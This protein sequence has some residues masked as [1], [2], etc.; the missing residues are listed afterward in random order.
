MPVLIT[1]CLASFILNEAQIM[2]CEH[3]IDYIVDVFI[4]CWQPEAEESITRE[5]EIP[6]MCLCASVKILGMQ[7]AFGFV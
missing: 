6:V 5:R 3:K 4:D 7:P 2:Q 1:T